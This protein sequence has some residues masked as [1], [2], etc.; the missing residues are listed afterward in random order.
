MHDD[1]SWRT[2]PRP[3]Q[4]FVAA[5]IAAGAWAVAAFFPHTWP[6]P[7][8]FAVLVLCSCVTASWKVN[9][10]ISLA[11]GSTLSV[12]YAAGLMALLLLGT[13]PA[14]LVAMAGAWTQC[15][16]FVKRPYPWY[17]T[18]FSVAAEAVTVVAT[19]FVYIWLGGGGP[20]DFATLPRPLVGAIAACFLVNTGLLA[21]AIALSLGQPILTIWH[22]DFVWCGPSFMVAGAAGAI[23][24]V[25]IQRDSEWIA[26]LM[27]APVYLTY[28]T[29]QV[30]L[31]RIEDHR[32]HVEEAERLHQEALD[33]LLQ[34]R[35]AEQALAEETERLTVTLR[36]IGD[37][38][39]TTDLDGT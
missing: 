33:A 37:G 4:I 7:I 10:P 9:L 13:G 17:R 38:V 8:L 16:V 27:L 26:V 39:I 1:L 24:A 31:G 21:C 19:G 12:A 28:R 5:V 30:Y 29:Y 20:L 32:R 23:A 11:S 15:T 35:R 6:H 36:S 25:L 2:L 22:E 18:A 3:A 14:I 34:A